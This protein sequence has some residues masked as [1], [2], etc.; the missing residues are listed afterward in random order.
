MT[1]SPSDGLAP[2]SGAEPGGVLF[3]DGV[4]KYGTAPTGSA[5]SGR[6]PRSSRAGEDFI[7]ETPSVATG[8]LQG[9]RLPGHVG[10]HYA[11]EMTSAAATSRVTSSSDPRQ[12]RHHLGD[13]CSGEMLDLPPVKVIRGTIPSATR[14]DG[15]APR[16]RR[17]RRGFVMARARRAQAG[18]GRPAPGTCCRYRSRSTSPGAP[19]TRC[20]RTRS[21]SQPLSGWL[22]RPTGAPR[23][24]RSRTARRA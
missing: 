17:R 3:D 22:V 18:P 24:R 8:A 13:R 6:S 14:C 23:T 12:P 7:M 11:P 10:L 9:P 19:D 20:A 15:L 1:S 2:G 5:R 4:H 16:L 21:T